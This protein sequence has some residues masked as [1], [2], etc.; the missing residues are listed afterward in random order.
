[1]YEP[2]EVQRAMNVVSSADMDN[3]TQDEGIKTID[4][5]MDGDGITDIAGNDT[6]IDVS[7]TAHKRSE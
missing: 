4:V 5:M 6:T 2:D 1:M 7:T 3:I